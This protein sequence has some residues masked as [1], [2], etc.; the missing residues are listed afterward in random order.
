[1]KIRRRGRRLSEQLHIDLPVDRFM[2]KTRP[3]FM[4]GSCFAMELRDY[5]RRHG[6]SLF[7]VDDYKQKRH[8][9]VLTWYNTYSILYEF[10]LADGRFDRGKEDWWELPDGRWQ[11]GIRRLRFAKSATR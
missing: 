10:L 7:E 2:N 1:M 5:M 3:V 4:L 8:R 11:C 6:Y 9:T